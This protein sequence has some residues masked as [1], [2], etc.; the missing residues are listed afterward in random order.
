MKRWMS[1]HAAANGMVVALAVAQLGSPPALAQDTERRAEAYFEQRFCQGMQLD[2]QLGEQRRADCLS[3]THAI[4]IDWHDKWREAVGQALA[5]SARTKLVPGVALVCRSDQGHCL[6][7]SAS[8][9]ETLEHHHIRASLWDCLPINAAL[10]DCTRW[11]IDAT[12]D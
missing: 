1:A 2:L 7:A 9:R 6:A 3:D 12:A 4:E 8:V 5:F 11:D 10:A